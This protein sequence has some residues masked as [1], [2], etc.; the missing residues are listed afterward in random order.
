MISKNKRLTLNNLVKGSLTFFFIAV[1][2]TTI[3]LPAS[4]TEITIDNFSFEDP[5]LGDGNY[6]TVIPNWAIS[7]GGAGV[8][9]PQ[10]GQS[11]VTQAFVEGIPD[12]LQVAY[13][14]GGDIEQTLTTTLTEGY[15]YTLKVWVG[16]RDIYYNQP[17]AVI[18]AGESTELNSVMGNNLQNE[19]IEQTLTYTVEL[20]DTNVGE[21]LTIKLINEGGVQVNFDKVTLDE[22]EILT[23]PGFHAPF[24]APITVNKKVK[25]ALPLKFNLYDV[26]GNEIT[27]ADLVKPPCVQ[28]MLSGAIGSD[29]DG[30]DVD[31]L[32]AGLS[33]DGNE[34]RYDH[35]SMQ[36]ILNLGLKAYTA[37]GT[38][39]ISVVAGDDSY[40]VE[41]CSETFTRQ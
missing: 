15:K 40:I 37:S 19:W 30:Y 9:D 22:A 29:I 18:L 12:P 38:Y 36:W 3:S 41:G 17:Y 32:P 21:K 31:L 14:N 24:D 1:L 26:S 23:S 5:A 16:G 34:F 10:V 33:D 25:R 39:T 28:V 8:W 2:I 27:D 35:D 11:D 20:G 4:A 7:G 13:S 6:N